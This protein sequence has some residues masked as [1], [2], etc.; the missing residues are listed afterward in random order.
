MAAVAAIAAR[1]A[2]AA[3]DATSNHAQLQPPRNRLHHH[4]TLRLRYDPAGIALQYTAIIPLQYR[5]NHLEK[6]LCR[7]C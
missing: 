7:P 6:A 4:R 2:A 1:D 5:Y 3:L